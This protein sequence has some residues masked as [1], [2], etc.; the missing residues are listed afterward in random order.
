MTPWGS[1]LSPEQRA[2]LVAFIRSIEGTEP[3]GAREPQGELFEEG[4]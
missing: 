1:I 4:A 2:Q 3:E